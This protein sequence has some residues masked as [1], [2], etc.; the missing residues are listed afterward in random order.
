MSKHAYLREHQ[1]QI[2]A[3]VSEA[4][5][6]AIRAQAAQPLRFIASLLD[7]SSVAKSK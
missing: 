6:A 5:A 2:E 3:R 7:Y 4:V 1:R